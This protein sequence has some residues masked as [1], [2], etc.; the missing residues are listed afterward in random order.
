MKTILTLFSLTAFLSQA[1]AQTTLSG[2]IVDGTGKPMPF[3]SVALLNA[4]DSSVA[5]GTAS[6]QQG[7]YLFAKVRAG[8]YVIRAT[9]VGYQKV[10]STAFEVANEPS[11]VPALKLTEMAGQLNTVQVTAKKPFVEQQIDRTVI[12]VAN[13][14]I[15]SGSTALEVLEKAP[16]V[17][18]DRQ[19]DQLQLRGKDGVIVQ[20]DGKQTYL[21][22][23]DVMAMLRSMSSDNVDRIELITN[24]S[25]RYDAA[26]NSGIIDIRLKKNNNVGTNGS[27][28]LA[29]GSGRYARQRG[30]LQLNHR[31]AKVNLFGSY[32]DNRG[33]NY[34]D[35]T[36]K[37]NQAAGS[38]LNPQRNIVDQRSYIRFW[39]R[40]QNVKA[41][42]DFFSSKSTTIGAVWTGFWSNIREESPADASFRRQE[43]GPVYLQTLTEKTLT[44]VPTNQIGNLN[45]QHTFG[46]KGGQLTADVDLGHFSREFTNSLTTRTLYSESGVTPL[47]G[48]F[49]HL[50]TTIDIL[51][52]KI[53][54]NR[55]L[56]GGWKMEAGLK[57]STVRSDN[58]LTL[59][60]GLAGELKLDDT[61]SNHFQYTERVNAAYATFTG[62]VGQ[63]TDVMLGLR[64]EHT[65]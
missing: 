15:A 20:I 42:M 65:H 18:V 11:N 8:Q 22:M 1:L 62:K 51:T 55:T 7:T 27:I 56:T 23:A 43:D 12:N 45:V 14:I 59:S 33:G 28:S 58:A 64:A 52:G 3:A 44:N 19:N 41:G 17:T 50:P 47:T 60:Q 32:S 30:S 63:K 31:T 39:E 13:S 34:W 26:G 53:D 5:K 29:G 25:A 2:N 16:G 9:A 37:R 57:S 54:Y 38:E 48:L 21:S 61:L 36:L 46:E 35:F 40:G 4:R 10:H 6:D 49:T 24:P